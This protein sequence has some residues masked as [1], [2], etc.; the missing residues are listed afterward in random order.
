M[1]RSLAV[2]PRASAPARLRLVDAHAHFWS[3]RGGAT[4]SNTADRPLSAAELVALM[5][6]FDVAMTLQVTRWFEPDDATSVRGAQAHPGRYRVLAR[7]DSRR[8]DLL[9][10]VRTA[11][12]RPHVVGLRVFDVET[13]T[14]LLRPDH[15]L[16]RLVADL[17]RP[18]CVY[19]PGE[20]AHLG[21]IA[22]AHPE[23]CLV[24]DHANVPL[25]PSSRPRRFAAW[26]DLLALAALPNVRVKASALPEACE[27]EFPFPEAQ[28]R[29]TELTGVFGADRVM[30]GSNFTPARRVGSYDEHVQFAWL[31][32]AMLPTE[33]QEAVLAGT[34]DRTF[35]LEL[36]AR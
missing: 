4:G 6:A 28:Q 35:G 21:E 27:E 23:L 13:N 9:A 32:T 22:A 2:P 34:A 25:T 16:W 29:L 12:L 5:D 26:A 33:S 7:T 30:W 18:V 1:T 24:L 17:H 14:D 20:T 19:A 11:L 3:A 10:R 36:G 15:D 31:A 8:P